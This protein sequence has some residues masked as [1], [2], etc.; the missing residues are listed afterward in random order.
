MMTLFWA[1]LLFN[2]AFF[3]VCTVATIVLI[4]SAPK[5]ENDEPVK[6]VRV[7]GSR[8]S[9]ASHTQFYQT[10]FGN[11][12]MQRSDKRKPVVAPPKS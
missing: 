1:I 12:I 7:R 2:V 10:R 8:E 9:Q 3:G 5:I 6:R 11:R 4:G